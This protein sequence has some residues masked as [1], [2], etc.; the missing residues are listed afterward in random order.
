M[1]DVKINL[2][3]DQTRRIIATCFA[4]THEIMS[5]LEDSQMKT[6]NT[7]L[8]KASVLTQ[9]TETSS[10]SRETEETNATLSNSARIPRK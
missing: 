9:P 8:N 3:D 10:V 5:L 2:T 1:S 7:A 4:F 6:L